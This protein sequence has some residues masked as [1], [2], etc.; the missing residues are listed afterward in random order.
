MLLEGNCATKPVETSIY[1]WGRLV[2]IAECAWRIGR[3]GETY[4]AIQKLL[5]IKDLPAD[6]REAMQKNSQL[7]MFDSYRYRF[8][9]V[10][11][12]L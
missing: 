1:K 5:A 8:L 3:I 4:E 6:T 2:Q 7:K 10:A 9:N 12:G 11:G